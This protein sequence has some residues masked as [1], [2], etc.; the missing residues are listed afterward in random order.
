MCG[1][2][3]EIRTDPQNTAYVVVSGAKK[4]DTGDDVVR[5]GDMV[6][7]SKEERDRMEEDAFAALEGRVEDKTMATGQRARIEELYERGEKDWGDPYKVSRIMRRGFRAERKVRE[8]ME[9]EREALKERVGWGE[10]MEI[11][12]ENEEDRRR[13]GMVDFG[14]E[15]WEKGIKRI[16]AKALFDEEGEKGSGSEKRRKSRSKGV[17]ESELRREKLV[18]EL[19][20][21][22]RAAMDPFL[23]AEKTFT[24]TPPALGIKRKRN[25][26]TGDLDASKTIDQ[27]SDPKRALLLVDYDSD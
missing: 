12:E 18:K 11:L 3:I 14:E 10:G 22:T 13:A 17:K 25:T 23:A 2:P 26:P 21:N 7:R 1:G 9:G 27:D 5:E 6:V 19:R 24:S 4:R 15:G 16:K 20:D 8:K